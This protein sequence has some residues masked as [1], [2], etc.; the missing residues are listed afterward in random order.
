MP[1]RLHPPVQRS[2]D[3]RDLHQP[4]SCPPPPPHEGKNPKELAEKYQRSRNVFQHLKGNYITMDYNLVSHKKIRD[5]HPNLF[6]HLPK[7]CNL[8]ISLSMCL[9]QTLEENSCLQ[10]GIVTCCNML[11]RKNAKMCCV[12]LSYLSVCLDHVMDLVNGLLDGNCD[13]SSRTRIIPILSLPA[14]NSAAHICSVP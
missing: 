3:P 10:N 13:G 4:L 8:K 1:T 12:P 7:I 5:L 11:C 9:Q 14:L 2:S 6:F